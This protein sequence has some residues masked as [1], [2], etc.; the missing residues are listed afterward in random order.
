[1][2]KESLYICYIESLYNGNNN[3]NNNNKEPPRRD[4]ESS[5]SASVCCYPGSL[6]CRFFPSIDVK[7]SISC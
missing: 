5:S 7:V 3:N 1:M 2:K 6:L 4:D